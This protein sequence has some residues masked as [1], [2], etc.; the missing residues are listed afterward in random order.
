MK[1]DSRTFKTHFLLAFQKKKST[2]ARLYKLFTQHCF[3]W[4][5]L[6]ITWLSTEGAQG[7]KSW[8]KVW[9]IMQ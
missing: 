9:N 1:I 2:N 7:N 6:K 3:Q 8:C 5:K 4:Q